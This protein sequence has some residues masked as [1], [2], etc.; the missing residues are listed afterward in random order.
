MSRVVVFT[1][2]KGGV[3]K[4]TATANVGISLALRGKRVIVIDADVGLRNLDMVLG[5]ENRIVYDVIDVLEDHVTPEK[6]LIRDKHTSNLYL[7]AASQTKGKELVDLEKFAKLVDHYRGLADYVLID[8]PAGIEHGFRVAVTPADVAVVVVNP[9]V[10]SVRD[11]DRVV[12][13][14]ESMDK[15]ES[16]ALVNRVQP[17]RVSRGETLAPEDVEDLLRIALVGIVPEDAKIVEASARG[18]PVALQNHS[19]AGY[20]FR[21]VASR[22]EGEQVPFDELSRAKKSFLERLFGR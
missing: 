8:C 20:A 16:Y 19:P 5:L 3:G 2:G 21:N 12:G 7:L 22:L 18:E 17:D 4:T 14:L 11:A 15:K 1:S 10:T 6:A 13:L 9:E